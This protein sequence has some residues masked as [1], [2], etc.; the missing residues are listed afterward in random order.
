MD[1]KKR[2][3]RIVNI[4]VQ[5]QSKRIVKAHEIAER[6]DI[7]LRTVYRDIKSLEQ[8]GVPIIG[9]A[10][11]GYSLVEDYKLPPVIFSKEEALSFIGAEKLMEKYMD[12]NLTQDF[13]SAMLKIKSILKSTFKD[14]L[15]TLENQ[16]KMYK[17]GVDTFNRDVPQALSLFFQSMASK[18]QIQLAYTGTK[19]DQPQERIVEP[20]GLF[21][22]NGFWYIAAF[23]LKRNDY[24]QFRADRIKNIQ[25]LETKFSQSETLNLE[26]F[27]ALHQNSQEY[28]TVVIHVHKEIAPYMHW[29]RKDYGFQEESAFEDYIEMVFSISNPD[30]FA[31]WY[32]MFADSA[33]IISPA[34]LKSKVIN[35]LEKSL[36]AQ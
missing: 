9:E 24:R 3:D 6:F 15:A 35:L 4:L 7:S 29:Q 5:L 36:T 25:L 8:A 28:Q 32:L 30:H 1:I 31:R 14:D 21:H 23:C 22:E 16:I 12:H 2:F 20:I 11:T 26:D 17:V 18:K 19:D 10:G 34:S 13:K 33:Q 27:I